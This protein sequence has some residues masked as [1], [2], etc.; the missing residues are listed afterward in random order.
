MRTPLLLA[1]L[2]LA[3]VATA[4]TTRPAESTQPAETT[5][6]AASSKEA[7]PKE[8]ATSSGAA[9]VG[10]PAPALSITGPD[11]AV[12]SESLAGKPVVL[13]F[14]ATWDKASPRLLEALDA[15]HREHAGAGLVVL[16]TSV[17]DGRNKHKVA[18]YVAGRGHTYPVHYDTSGANLTRWSGESRPA[19]HAV[20]GKDGTV[21]HLG[22][23]TTP[24]ALASLAAAA[25]G[26]L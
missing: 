9:T 4:E 19:F 16:S 5:R 10:A 20:V 2:A 11:G 7:A 6:P 15:L 13:A 8:K 24:E 22:R 17:D 3:S 12:T 18:P 1:L 21:V 23:E 25:R 14:W 26:A